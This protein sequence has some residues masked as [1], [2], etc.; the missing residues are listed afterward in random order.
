ME[1]KYNSNK[2]K[3]AEWFVFKASSPNSPITDV[4]VGGCSS[5]KN[6]EQE[7]ARDLIY[8]IIRNHSKEL[9]DIL[10]KDVNLCARR[11]RLE[12]PCRDGKG[13]K[14]TNVKQDV[15][16]TSD[17]VENEQLHMTKVLAGNEE[18]VDESEHRSVPDSNKAGGDYEEYS[19]EEIWWLTPGREEFCSGKFTRLNQNDDRCCSEAWKLLHCEYFF[20]WN[21][22]LPCF[23]F[24]FGTFSFTRGLDEMFIFWSL[25]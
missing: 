3:R 22:L 25:R 5:L 9:A 21:V 19:K 6:A 10:D 12:N 8:C 1:M 7:A 23:V 17:G 18:T 11:G 15:P 2:R 4:G 13:K 24:P 16:K 20:W 14:E